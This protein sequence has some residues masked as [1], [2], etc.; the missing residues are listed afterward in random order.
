[1]KFFNWDSIVFVH[2]KTLDEEEGTFAGESLIEGDFVPSIVDLG[3]QVLHLVGVEWRLANH[4]L[5]QHD[6][7]SPCVDLGTVASLFQQLW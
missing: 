7:K 3:D 2:L 5:I 4:H 1:M 6:T